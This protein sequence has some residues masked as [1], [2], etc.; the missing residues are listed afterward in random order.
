VGGHTQFLANAQGMPPHIETALKR[1]IS[2]FILDDDSSSR[3]TCDILCHI[4]NEGGLD[5]LDIVIRNKAID[6]MWLKRY[7]D[8]SPSHPT[9]AAITNIIVQELAPKCVLR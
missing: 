5:L 6:V 4:I 7:L 3:I 1:I 8:F 2:G 9:W